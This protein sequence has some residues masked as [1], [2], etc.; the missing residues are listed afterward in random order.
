VRVIVSGWL[1]DERSP[2]PLLR[3]TRPIPSVL[4]LQTTLPLSYSPLALQ[5]GS[6]DNGC[7]CRLWSK[8]NSHGQ[9]GVQHPWLPLL[10][11]PPAAAN[12]SSFSLP[13]RRG[14][15][16]VMH[17]IATHDARLLQPSCM[18]GNNSRMVSSL[19]SFRHGSVF[20]LHWLLIASS[21]LELISDT[22]ETTHGYPSGPPH[23]RC[24]PEGSPMSKVDHC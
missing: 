4:A 10:M 23:R 17:N 9:A 16:S 13:K 20:P 8:S 24:L 22:L 21:L 19:I 15:H 12:P 1:E 5:L 2:D 7:N 3:T 18:T 14:A 11:L 6:Y